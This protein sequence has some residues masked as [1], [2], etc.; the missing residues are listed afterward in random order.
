VLSDQDALSAL[1]NAVLKEHDRTL[2]DLIS[3][4]KQGRGGTSSKQTYKRF[5]NF[6]AG[7]VIK[8]SQ[9]RAHPKLASELVKSALDQTLRAAGVDSAIFDRKA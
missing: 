9:G 8:R 5:V 6:C 1:C 2:T 7:E 4:A 3:Q